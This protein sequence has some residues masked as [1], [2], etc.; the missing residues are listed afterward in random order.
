MSP[1]MVCAMATGTV[2]NLDA[3]Q[4]QANRNSFREDEPEHRRGRRPAFTC[5]RQILKKTCRG[6]TSC[7]ARRIL[8][9][10]RQLTKKLFIIRSR[11]A[12]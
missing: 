10:G 12:G 6:R 7:R 3:A 9:V 4:Q 1:P 8:D 2:R 5:G 11:T